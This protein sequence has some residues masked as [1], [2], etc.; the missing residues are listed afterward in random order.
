MLF[1]PG[2]FWSKLHKESSW[3][4]DGSWFSTCQT[5]GHFFFCLRRKLNLKTPRNREKKGLKI[6][7]IIRRL[8]V[9]GFMGTISSSSKQGC[10][11]MK[12]A[13]SEACGLL[14]IPAKTLVFFQRQ[15]F[16]FFLFFPLSRHSSERHKQNST[17]SH[18]FWAPGNKRK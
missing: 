16:F 1:T 14:P 4:Q 3:L 13:D 8:A 18:C 15:L 12:T 2:V 10:F 6:L 9:S 11:Q 17:R 5:L 7:L